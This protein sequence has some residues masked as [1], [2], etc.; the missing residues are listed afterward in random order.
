MQK[1]SI[2]NLKGDY[3]NDN[4]FNKIANSIIVSICQEM[5]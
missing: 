3:T 5:G 2:E 4:L 1:Q